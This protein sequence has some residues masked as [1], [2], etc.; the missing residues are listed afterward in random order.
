[1]AEFKW[2]ENTKEIYEKCIN[3]APGPFRKITKKTLDECL[4]KKLGD[5]GTVTE[6][7]LVDAI[8]EC[9]PKPFLKMGMKQLK[10]LL[11]GEYGF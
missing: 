1:M 11:K 7:V 9:T 3:L 2:E 4:T 8:K 6:P 10:P 5:G